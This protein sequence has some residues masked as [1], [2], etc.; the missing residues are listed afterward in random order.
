MHPDLTKFTAG[1]S[2]TFYGSAKPAARAMV[3]LAGTV[4]AAGLAVTLLVMTN[5]QE[6]ATQ[7][8]MSGMSPQQAT[9]WLQSHGKEACY[10][11]SWV[12]ADGTG[13]VRVVDC[14]D[15]ELANRQIAAENS[16]LTSED[17]LTTAAA[18]AGR[19]DGKILHPVLLTT[20]RG[21]AE[22]RVKIGHTF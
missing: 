6:T 3:R 15:I 20:I 18:R 1:A 7:P 2:S 14:S 22:I 11:P 19:Y 13:A 16:K 9:A 17:V 12:T 8:R 10:L 4:A 21:P 5:G